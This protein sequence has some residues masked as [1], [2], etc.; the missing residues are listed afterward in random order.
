MSESTNLLTVE[1]KS[2]DHLGYV[3]VVNPEKKDEVNLKIVNDA[4]EATEISETTAELN[5]EDIIRTA[6]GYFAENG[7]IVSVRFLQVWNN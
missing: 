7:L 6:E 5:A 3:R 2:G 1:S 4:S